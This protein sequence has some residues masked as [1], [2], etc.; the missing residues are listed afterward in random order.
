MLFA[1]RLALAPLLLAAAAGLIGHN[2]LRQL[3]TLLNPAPD[4]ARGVP[5]EEHRRTSL[6][7]ELRPEIF[8]DVLD[9]EGELR[10]D[11][12]RGYSLEQ[13][14]SFA[15]R[16]GRS[17]SSS[18]TALGRLLQAC[19]VALA[20]SLPWL[21]FGVVPAAAMALL[22]RRTRRRAASGFTSRA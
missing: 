14:P 12:L 4:F 21:V 19:V 17:F 22:L 5:N 1:A 11:E 13:S 18:L 7:V 6:C 20:M 2:R 15:V 3:V 9:F 16:V 8:A 10:V